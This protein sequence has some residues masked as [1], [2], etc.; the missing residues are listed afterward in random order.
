MNLVLLVLLMVIV[1]CSMSNDKEKNAESRNSSN[2]LPLEESERKDKIDTLKLSFDSNDSIKAY[3][4]KVY[5]K[6]K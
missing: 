3:S 6:I 4:D 2:L 1:S 5:V